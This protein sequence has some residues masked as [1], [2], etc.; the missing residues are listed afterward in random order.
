PL[1][2]LLVALVSAFA[3]PAATALVVA[4]AVGLEGG[5]RYFALGE[6]SLTSFGIHTA[7]L[8]VFAVLNLVLLRVQI[9]K[10][11]SASRLRLD[12]E[13]SKMRD[14]ARSYRLLGATSSANEHLIVRA[15]D[16]DRLVHSSVEEIHQAVLF[17]LDLV[18]QSLGLHTGM[19]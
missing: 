7:F 17:A 5:I 18:R 11:R 6:T 19:L 13:L 10:I 1:V 9:A 12:T 4:L 2:Y 3:H 15:A 16:G 14:A 8:I